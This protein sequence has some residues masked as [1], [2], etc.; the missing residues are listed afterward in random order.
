MNEDDKRFIREE[1]KNIGVDWQKVITE[2]I[3]LVRKSTTAIVEVKSSLA[4][5]GTPPFY[6]RAEFWIR[7]VELVIVLI[8][9]IIV[10]QAHGCI[11]VANLFEAG[12]CK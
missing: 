1:L 6:K 3:D 9:G 8:V 7:I 4:G 11:M 2:L 12:F 10:I 5:L